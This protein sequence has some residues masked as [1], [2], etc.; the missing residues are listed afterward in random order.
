MMTSLSFPASMRSHTDR[1][2]SFSPAAAACVILKILSS[3]DDKIPYLRDQIE[4]LRLPFRNLLTQ[5]MNIQTIISDFFVIA[6]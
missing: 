5:K 4:R 2:N 6:Y 3:N 1:I